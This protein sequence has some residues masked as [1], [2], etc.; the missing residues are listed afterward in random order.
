[1]AED[2]QDEEPYI[3]VVGKEWPVRFA[4]AYAQ[5]ADAVVATESLIANS[6]AFE[7]MLKVV[8]LSH[9][10]NENLT[11][12]WLNTAAIEPTVIACHPCHRIHNAGAVFCAKDTTTGAAAYTQDLSLVL[13]RILPA[14]SARS[15][16]GYLDEI[17]LYVLLKRLVD[18]PWVGHL[19]PNARELTGRQR[20]GVLTQCVSPVDPLRSINRQEHRRRHSGLLQKLRES[21]PAEHASGRRRR[22]VHDSNPGGDD[23]L[24]REHPLWSPPS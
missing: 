24:Q 13:G 4:L 18:V 21:I 15:F 11:K 12:H 16:Q 20:R 7:T 17:A 19:K 10:S 23:S 22:I 8:T 1:M 14:D 6:V 9:S 2:I 5:V 3:H